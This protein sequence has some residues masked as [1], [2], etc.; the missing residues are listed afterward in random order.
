MPIPRQSVPALTL[1]TLAHGGYD[2]AAD[3][4]GADWGVLLVA[5][6]GLH[7]PI[8]VPYLKELERLTPEFAQRGVKTIAVST[9]DAERAQ[10][11]ATKVGAEQLRVGYGLGLE[12]AREWGLFISTSKG[13]TSIGVEEP[14]LFAEP[15]VF[16][17]RSDGTLYFSS[18]QTMPF[19][20]PHFSEMIGALDFVQKN[21]YPARGEYTGAV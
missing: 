1:E 4:A 17:I 6:R 11:M 9:D 3:A 16:L 2:L 12:K 14:A 10:K 8:C 18:I 15:G 5:Y 7:C 20:R 19:A 21:D 13:V